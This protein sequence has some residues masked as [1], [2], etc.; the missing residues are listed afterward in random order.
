MYKKEDLISDEHV[1]IIKP[2]IKSS[3]L[4]NLHMYYIM[5]ILCGEGHKERD[6]QHLCKGVNIMK[7]PQ[8]I[9]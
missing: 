7:K 5:Y 2:L 9:I 8:I 3:K 1:L 4:T 6:T